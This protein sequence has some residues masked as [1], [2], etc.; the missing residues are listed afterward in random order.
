MMASAGERVVLREELSKGVAALVLNRPEKLNALN[1]A[2]LEQLMEGIDECSADND[3]RVIVIRG[4]GR[5]FSAGADTSG[6]PRTEKLTASE[7]RVHM[8]EERCGQFVRLWDAPKPVI[9]QIHGHC[10]GISV[11]LCS[12]ADLVVV[13]DDAVIGWPLPLGGGIIGPSW[14]FHVGARKAKE[15]SFQAAS[16]LSGTEAAEIGWANHAVPAGELDA[17]VASL[18]ARIARTPPG[19]LRIK[20]EAINSVYDRLGFRDVAKMGASWDAL[21]HTI[22]D[23]DEVKELMQ[24][25]GVKGAIAY[26]QRP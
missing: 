9:A 2:L 16:R 18:A 10:L 3:V 12:F 19:L 26:Y 25:E 14:V 8:L 23:I 11:A 17:Y 21:A 4:A 5:S 13:A 24:R 15:Y 7:D 22:G 1:N 6:P 20:K